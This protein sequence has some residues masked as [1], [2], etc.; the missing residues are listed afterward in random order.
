[1]NALLDAGVISRSEADEI[2]ALM[3]GFDGVLGVIGEVKTEEALPKE[4]EALIKQREA[5]RKAGN[6]A[7][8]DA[9]RLK[10]REMGVVVEDTPQ[11]VR[12]RLEKK[13]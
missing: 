9:L 11:G 7:R 8:A 6:W 3:R 5:A 1:M 13:S 2:G 12:W 10:L 4:A